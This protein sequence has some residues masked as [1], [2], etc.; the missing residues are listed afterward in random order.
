MAAHSEA[1]SPQTTF[2]V[3]LRESHLIVW[4]LSYLAGAWSFVQVV[5]LL[6]DVFAWH[7]I[8]SRA[9]VLC[10]AWG[11]PVAVVFAWFHGPRG[12]QRFA[13]LEIVL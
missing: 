6:S 13:A 1:D 5:A 2:L 3:R 7:E 9:A 4:L 8:V 12:R 10:A 11:V